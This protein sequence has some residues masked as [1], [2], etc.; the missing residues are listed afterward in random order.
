MDSRIRSL[1]K[2]YDRKWEAG[3]NVNERTGD[4][5]GGWTYASPTPATTGIKD[6]SFSRVM[7]EWSNSADRMSVKNGD[8][9]RTT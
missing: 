6:I 4:T 1:C 9:D 5:K 3:I 2:R 8:E 7:G